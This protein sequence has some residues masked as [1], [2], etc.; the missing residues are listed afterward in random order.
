MLICTGGPELG[1]EQEKVV[2]TAF[3]K[4]IQKFCSFVLSGMVLFLAAGAIGLPAADAQQ[5]GAQKSDRYFKATTIILPDGKAIEEDKII[6]PP[7][8]PP[9]FELERRAVLLPKTYGAAGIQTLT[10]PAYDWLY[11]CSAVSGAMIA[12]YYDRNGYPD[13]YTGPTNGGVMPM[14]NSS[15]PLW[16]DGYTTYPSC[17]LVAS[18]DGL[19]GRSTY[20][21]IDDYWVKY[22][23]LAADPYIGNWAQHTWGDA[24]GDY[25]KTSQSAYN[26]TDGGTTFYN[27]T[28]GSSPLTCSDMVT[29]GIDTLDGTY[30]RKLFYE[31]RG[32]TVTDCYNQKT[33]NQVSGGFAFA[34]FKAE[35]DAGHPVMLNLAG[36]T[37]VGI[38]YDDAT[39][40]V[41]IH[42]TWDYDTHTMTWG[43]SYTG[44]TLL[45]VSIVDLAPLPT[46]QFQSG[47]S[48]GSE[49]TSPAS[50]TV[51]LSAISGETVTV[52]YATS[53]G[54]AT[55]G[56]D[57]TAT[58]GTITFSPGDT[59]ET[60]N[61][62]ISNDSSEEGDETFTVTLSSPSKA[63]L[64]APASHTYTIL[65]DDHSGSIQLSSPTYGVSEGGGTVTITATRTGGS[66]GVVG[67]NYSTSSGTA[68]AGHDYTSSIGNLSWSNGDSASKT[69]NVTITDDSLNEQNETFTASLSSP[70]G[71]AT[72]GS[73]SSATVTITD[74]DAVANSMVYNFS[75]DRHDDTIHD[76]LTASGDAQEIGCQA[77]DS[78]EDINY[79][80]PYAVSLRGGYD[81]YFSDNSGGMTRVNTL[82]ITD[83][84]L[85][86]EN[87]QIGGP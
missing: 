4:K 79:D 3:N 72:L 6:G 44:R 33:D 35:I 81:S 2:N 20:G 53:N 45:S 23:S 57:Y 29:Q 48:S 43:G 84:T 12:A 32:Y 8:P 1:Q 19:E 62:P 73:P 59:S 80:S 76:A 39:S 66:D 36:H 37:V 46:V 82:T 16:S 24:I 13:I 85:T 7:K 47:S 52:H 31:E 87:F 50:I 71:G 9:G 55:A 56:S 65:N 63:N 75:I 69:F 21:S 5:A 34:Q 77:F 67:V 61:V 86:I 27:W 60:I 17:P 11:G 26:N 54:T 30:G 42:D 49:A 38:G 70:T 83:G 58:S 10:V 51:T 74:N 41:Y 28:S 18:M 25:M 40:T 64:G 22:E 14:D 78:A 68:T 15:W